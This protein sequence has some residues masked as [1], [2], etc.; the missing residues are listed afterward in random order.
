MKVPGSRDALSSLL[1]GG[2]SITHAW[3][4]SK[5]N[6]KKN[7]KLKAASAILGDGELSQREKIAKLRELGDFKS[8]ESLSKTRLT[9]KAIKY[10]KKGFQ[11]KQ[12]M[13]DYHI[14]DTDRKF[15]K[16]V[17]DTGWEHNHQNEVFGET[18][19]QNSINNAFTERKINQADRHHEEGLNAGTERAIIKAIGNAVRG[20]ATGA[21]LVFLVKN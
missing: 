12:R 9:D 17:A 14:G 21:E 8:A 18:K 6:T 13:D 20:K 1:R 19:K 11:E 4:A 2:A 3:Q 15:N 16:S 10:K 5:D 7:N